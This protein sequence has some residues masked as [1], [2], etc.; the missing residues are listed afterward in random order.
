MYDIRTENRIGKMKLEDIINKWDPV[1]LFPMAPDDEYEKEIKRIGDYINATEEIC[2]KELA[3]YIS[4]IF[5]A[6]FGKDVFLD[7]DE[8][9]MG[10]AENILRYLNG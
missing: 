8:E 10:I 2:A 9:C 3:E 4:Q 7:N 5:S 1:G 6:A